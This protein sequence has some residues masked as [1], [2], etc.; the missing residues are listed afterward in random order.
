[1]GLNPTYLTRQR[2]RGDGLSTAIGLEMVWPVCVQCAV[3]TK[4][5]PISQRIPIKKPDPNCGWKH[6]ISLILLFINWNI[7][8]IST[9]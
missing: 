6:K 2:V 5:C 3:D 8:Y 4:A 9:H 1:M 7:K